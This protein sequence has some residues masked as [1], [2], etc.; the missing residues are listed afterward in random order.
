MFSDE[1]EASD[2]ESL[3]SDKATLSSGMEE[4]SN[5]SLLFILLMKKKMH[6]AAY[7]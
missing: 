7:E 3:G 5:Q 2:T 4:S 1:N 6:G